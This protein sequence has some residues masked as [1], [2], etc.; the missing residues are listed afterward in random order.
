[1]H[2]DGTQ[3]P[4]TIR[5]ARQRGP[6]P[7]ASEVEINVCEKVAL[8]AVG[9][10]DF[11]VARLN[12]IWIEIVQSLGDAP[13]EALQRFGVLERFAEGLGSEQQGVG[14]A[15]QFDFAEQ[16]PHRSGAA[17]KLDIS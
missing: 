1:M 5:L 8:T 12:R 6:A 17:A 10:R 9:Q 3:R 7:I 4:K 11:D 16:C 13:S 14:I 2:R 15:P